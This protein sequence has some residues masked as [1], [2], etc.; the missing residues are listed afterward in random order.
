MDSE[1]LIA[2]ACFLSVCITQVRTAEG[3]QALSHW[4]GC[5]QADCAWNAVG[6]GGLV[7]TS[8]SVASGSAASAACGTVVIHFA[9]VSVP[10]SLASDQA[11][12]RSPLLVQA[13][14][15]LCHMEQMSWLSMAWSVCAW[16]VTSSLWRLCLGC[17]CLSSW[18]LPSS[19]ELTV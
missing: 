4:T 1:K 8:G 16:T 17:L 9:P 19:N 14:P 15:L 7:C 6:G 12:I 5:E 10:L 2:S 18:L 11:V 3:C 13:W